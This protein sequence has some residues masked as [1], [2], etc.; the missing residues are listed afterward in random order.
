MLVPIFFIMISIY[1]VYANQ[2]KTIEWI[3]NNL[4]SKPY[5]LVFFGDSSIRAVGLC[6][7]G[8]TGIDQWLKKITKYSVLP[9]ESP[10][11]SPIVYQDFISAVTNRLYKPKT[12]IIP[13][14]LRSFSAQWFTNPN[15][16]FYTDRIKARIKYH[17]FSL[18][19]FL[20]YI[21][22]QYTDKLDQEILSW[23]RT[24]IDYGNDYLGTR[25]SLLERMKMPS[26]AIVDCNPA[27]KIVYHEQLRLMFLYRYMNWINSDHKMLDYLDETIIQARNNNIDVVV[28]IMPVNIEDGEM[29]VGKTF[30]PRIQENIETISKRILSHDIE[31]INLAFSLPPERFVD[32]RYVCEHLDD[33]GRK[34]V[35]GKIAVRLQTKMTR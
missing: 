14:N 12:I 19:D 32:K 4:D 23:D 17:A 3:E 34:Y 18:D 35:A 31:F 7:T 8:T 16:Q 1:D 28:Y 20:N 22:Y 26:G 15:Y 2:H 9:A 30:K 24:P 5:D 10:A 33:L 25:T 21:R 27:L 6:D 11:F 29:F 13:I